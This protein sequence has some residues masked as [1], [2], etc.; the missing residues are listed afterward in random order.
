MLLLIRVVE[1]PD[2]F[3]PACASRVRIR[4]REGSGVT[5]ISVTPTQVAD[6]LA[7]SLSPAI[8]A[9]TAQPFHPATDCGLRLSLRS[10]CGATSPCV[11]SSSTCARVIQFERVRE[12]T[13]TDGHAKCLYTGTDERLVSGS[14]VRPQLACFARLGRN[15][16]RLR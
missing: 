7:L 5:R 4:A 2:I 1:R 6:T 3:K 8:Q 12:P 14:S 16:R 11:P 15:S 9:P 13:P 10:Q